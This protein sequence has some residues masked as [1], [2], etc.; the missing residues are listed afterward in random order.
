[1]SKRLF[2]AYF[3]QE[4]EKAAEKIKELMSKRQ[5]YAGLPVRQAVRT[6]IS[7]EEE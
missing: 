7:K 6:E 3:E 2:V 1:M 5:P 4:E